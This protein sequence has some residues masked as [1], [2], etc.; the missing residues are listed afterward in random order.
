MWVPLTKFIGKLA[1][2]INCVTTNSMKLGN[3][4]KKKFFLFSS[5]KG[6]HRG[7]LTFWKMKNLKNF[8]C[9]KG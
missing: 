7:L 6:K 9:V 5:Q 4:L 3:E 8:M 2:R 1:Q